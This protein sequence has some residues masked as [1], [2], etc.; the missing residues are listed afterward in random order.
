[1]PGTTAASAGTVRAGGVRTGG[2]RTEGPVAC[3]DRRRGP[4]RRGE[5]L[6]RA[7]FDAVLAELGEHG[8]ARLTYDGVAARAGTGKSSLYRRW[9]TKA[10]LVVDTLRHALPPTPAEAATP[11]IRNVR[12]DLRAVLR[13]MAGTLDG[14]IGAAIASLIAS[15]RE[16]PELLAAVRQRVIEPR[17]ALLLEVLAAGV[18]RGEVRPDALNA[19]VVAVGPTL[20][21][22]RYLETR[23]RIP[24]DAIDALVDNVLLPL[25]APR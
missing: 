12:A 11:R 8:F 22:H 15:S 16:H 21:L 25:L 4:R 5:V 19:D 24:D 14:P 18:E 23:T 2:V 10:D 20:L 6:E 3:G 17:R 7:I 9:P 13:R 1:M